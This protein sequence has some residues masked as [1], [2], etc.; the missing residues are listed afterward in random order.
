MSRGTFFVAAVWLVFRGT[1]M[2]VNKPIGDNARNQK[3][4]GK[5]K[6]VRKER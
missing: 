4:E 1:S 2:A 6:V 5:F 3:E